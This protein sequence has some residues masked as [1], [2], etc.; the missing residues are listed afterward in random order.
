LHHQSRT[1]K[2]FEIEIAGENKRQK[3]FLP[4]LGKPHKIYRRGAAA[5]VFF[6]E[7]RFF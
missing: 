2:Y 7:I 1:T 3:T 4:L 5:P 6:L